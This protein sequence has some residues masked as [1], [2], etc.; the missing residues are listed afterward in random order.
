V[1]VNRNIEEML[2]ATAAKKRRAPPKDVESSAEKRHKRQDRRKALMDREVP[3]YT[4]GS[5]KTMIK[6][7]ST[8]DAECRKLFA[9]EGYVSDDEPEL[10]K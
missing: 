8:L 5:V 9:D 7:H 2:A 6:E 4:H 10:P 1:P 3:N